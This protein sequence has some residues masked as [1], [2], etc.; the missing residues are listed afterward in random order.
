[1]TEVQQAVATRFD[2]RLERRRRF[3]QLL[4]VVLFFATL[5]GLLVLTA[6]LVDVVRK[7]APWL[8]WQFLTSYPSRRPEAAGIK[9]AIVGSFWLMLLTALFSVPIGVGAAVYLEEYAPRGWLLRLIQLNIANLAGIPSVIY[10]ILGLGLFVRFFAL[11]RSLLAG[12]LTMSLLVLPIIVISTQEALRAV[13][14]GIR[15]SAYALGATRWQVVS[16]HLLPIAAPGI[17][18]G[19]ILALSRAVGETAP[20]VMIGALTFVAFL[21]SHVLDP[22]TVLPIQIFNWTARPQET[23]RGLAAA[24]IIVLMVFLFLMNLSAILLRNYYERHRPH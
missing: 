5:F 24:A 19:I 16:S 12:A 9:S 3:G 22:F 7:G 2:L 23:F 14:Q 17:L 1:M 15:E 21:P 20:L 18:T 13:P 6:L 4:A 10:G 8:D 11:G